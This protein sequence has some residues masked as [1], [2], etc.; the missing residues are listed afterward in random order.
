M[1]EGMEAIAA[2]HNL[3]DAILKHLELSHWSSEIENLITEGQAHWMAVTNELC[4][5]PV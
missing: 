1:S 4:S 2:V 3:H 5:N